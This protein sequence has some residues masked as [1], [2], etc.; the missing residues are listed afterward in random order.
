M[1]KKTKKLKW[2][3]IKITNKCGI[4]KTLATLHVTIVEVCA[5][6]F[7]FRSWYSFFRVSS[8][9]YNQFRQCTMIVHIHME[10]FPL[11]AE[12]SHAVNNILYGMDDHRRYWRR[13]RKLEEWVWAKKSDSPAH[14]HQRCSNKER[15]E[16]TREM[17]MAKYNG[18]CSFN[19]N[20]K[21]AEIITWKE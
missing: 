20:W 21:S 3:T 9:L 19:S 6:E 11:S 18:R 8:I 4:K 17:E 5:G 12:S 13:V 10:C 2:G 1:T 16:W 14:R 15:R 7:D